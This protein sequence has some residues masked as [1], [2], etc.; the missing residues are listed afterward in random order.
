MQREI[1]EMRQKL[2]KFEKREHGMQNELHHLD[3][4]VGTIKRVEDDLVQKEAKLE[5][6]LEEQKEGDD[7]GSDHVH[8]HPLMPH[9]GPPRD[10]GA[11][12]HDLGERI[13]ERVKNL[14]KE[15]FGKDHDQPGDEKDEGPL[16]VF[17]MGPFPFP[18]PG[19]LKADD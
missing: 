16:R 10:L 5:K 7:W 3:G 18:I 2:E 15:L 19:F 8:M 1:N 14:R 12:L 17:R 6:E 4:R 11:K 9:F 13:H